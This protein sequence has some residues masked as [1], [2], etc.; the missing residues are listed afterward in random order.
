MI[1]ITYIKKE[2]LRMI[3]KR[4][5][6]KEISE[7]LLDKCNI[8]STN[9]RFKSTFY[10]KE[11]NKVCISLFAKEFKED[12]YCQLVTKTIPADEVLTLYIIRQDE[13]NYNRAYETFK[14][15]K[16][17][18]DYKKYCIPIDELEIIYKDFVLGEDNSF[19]DMSMRDY[20]CIHLKTAQSNKEWLNNLIN[21]ING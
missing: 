14:S 7:I 11:L 12:F 21:N 1:Y 5:E 3:N 17:G 19:K 13:E 10:S 2:F 15:E 16:F 4:L 18:T 20:A 9:C 6:D 8:N